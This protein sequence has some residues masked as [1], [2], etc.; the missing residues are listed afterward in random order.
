MINRGGYNIDYNDGFKYESTHFIKYESIIK[1]VLNA[2]KL[3]LT[4]RSIVDLKTGI[5]A[6]AVIE[7]NVIGVSLR[8]RNQDYNSFTLNRHITDNNSEIHKWL[9]NRNE[10]IKPSFHIQISKAKNFNRVIRINIDSFS[11]YI[12]YLINNNLLESKYN[13]NL[14]SYEFSLESLKDVGGVNSYKI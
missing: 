12:Q 13:H 3:E 4:T 14:K 9:K 11:Y 6:Y 8:F 2:S 7:N 5:D 10:T 1:R